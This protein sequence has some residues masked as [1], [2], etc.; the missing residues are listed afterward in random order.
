MIEYK[1]MD[2]IWCRLISTRNYWDLFTF[3]TILANRPIGL[4]VECS[5]KARKARVQPQIESYQ[6]LKKWYLLPP[7][8]TLSIKRY[9]SRVGWSNPGKGVTLS[10]TPRCSRCWKGSFRL[11]LGYGRQLYYTSTKIYQFV[12]LARTRHCFIHYINI[13]SGSLYPRRK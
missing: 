12:S 5:L 10:P 4:V 11:A 8:L 13:S 1:T 2:I 7:C 6:R 9:V 3:V